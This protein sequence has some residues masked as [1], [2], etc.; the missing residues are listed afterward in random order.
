MKNNSGN[1]QYKKKPNI[2][3]SLVFD[4]ADCATMLDLQKISLI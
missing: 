3:E 4:Y 2:P 1:S